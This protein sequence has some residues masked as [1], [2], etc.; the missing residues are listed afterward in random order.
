MT[1]LKIWLTSGLIW[2]EW[3]GDYVYGDIYINTDVQ[4]Y[5]FLKIPMLLELF[6]VFNVKGQINC[7][8]KLRDVYPFIYSF[9]QLTD[10]Y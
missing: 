7:Q 3:D 6:F 8:D 10:T 4:I 9:I 2:V 1:C 5:T